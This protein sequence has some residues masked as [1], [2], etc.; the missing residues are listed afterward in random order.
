VLTGTAPGRTSAAQLTVYKSTGHAVE[1]V[2]AAA[3]A[4]RR[5]RERGI[6]KV[7]CF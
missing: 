4:Y 6:G 7:F 3:L 5:A 2:A 1:D